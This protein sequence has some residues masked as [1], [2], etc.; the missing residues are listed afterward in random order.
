MI[1]VSVI[2]PV[3]NVERYLRKCLD[4]LLCQTLEEIEFIAVNDGSTD[5]SQEILNEYMQKTDK[6]RCFIKENGGLSD[7]R[8]YGFPFA[9]GEYIGYVDSDDFVDADMFQVMYEKAKES[10]SDIVECNLRHVFPDNSRDVEIMERF[11]DRGSL[12]CFGRHVVWNK[13][14]RRTWLAQTKVCFP[15]GL[16]YEDVEFF[17]KLVP[18]IRRYDYVDIAPIY[19]VQRA[20]SINNFASAKTMHIFQILENIAAFYKEN[21]FY[22]EYERQLEYLYSRILL[23]SSFSRMCCIPD[24]SIRGNALHK[25][26]TFL[27]QAYPN[28]RRNP[29]LKE[30]RSRHELFMKTI[31]AATYAVYGALLPLAYTIRRK[32]SKKWK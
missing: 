22:A 27:V 6:L 25:N 11:Y 7:A 31:N 16:I 26:W 20:G 3:Y 8:N 5:S 23:C 14:Y 17:S 32:L 19:Y 2:V 4:S 18:Y 15:V 30:R 29:V 9:G 10:D 28:W 21:G 12:L 1:K 13:I 24:A